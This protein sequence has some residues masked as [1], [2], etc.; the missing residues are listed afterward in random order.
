MAGTARGRGVPRLQTQPVPGVLHDQALSRL[1]C[2]QLMTDGLPLCAIL[3]KRESHRKKSICSISRYQLGDCFFPICCGQCA[4]R[5][6]RQVRYILLDRARVNCTS[7]SEQNCRALYRSTLKA[8]YGNI[9]CIQ[10]TTLFSLSKNTAKADQN[11]G[12]GWI[13]PQLPT[14]VNQPCE[15]D[16][17]TVAR[18][19]T[20]TA[21]SSRSC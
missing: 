6:R 13:E 15:A 3:I 21:S 9:C 20:H 10:L 8:T 5:Y 7:L 19:I 4:A 14:T 11:Q 2:S 18:R 16:T 17:P 1:C 12:Q